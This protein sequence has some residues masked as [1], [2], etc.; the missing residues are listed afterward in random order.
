MRILTA[1]F[2][3]V[4][5]A[6]ACQQK[7]PQR[8]DFS[9]DLEHYD[10]GKRFMSIEGEVV[11]V[12]EGAYHADVGTHI[13][14]RWTELLYAQTKDIRV[15]KPEYK[16]LASVT[17]DNG[18]GVTDVHIKESSGADK[19]DD[20]LLQA[21]SESSPVPAPPPELISEGETFTFDLRWEIV[22]KNPVQ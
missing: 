18:G 3:L 10:Q 9:L 2:A 16:M 13:Q 15:P 6:T 14:D 22:N 21:I 1:A 19:L 4:F 20:L 12:D 17:V 11:M 5:V 7:G 8:P